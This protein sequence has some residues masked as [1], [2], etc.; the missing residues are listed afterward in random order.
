MKF[1]KCQAIGVR[2]PLKNINTSF[3]MTGLLGLYS[4]RSSNKNKFVGKV[5]STI[6]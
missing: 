6:A 2:N 5:M 1:W 3:I 4:N